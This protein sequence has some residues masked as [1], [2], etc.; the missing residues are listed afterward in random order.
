MVDMKLLTDIELAQLTAKTLGKPIIYI[1]GFG[2]ENVA[3]DVKAA[4]YLANWQNDNENMA[5]LLCDGSG[6]ILCDNEE[7]MW[8]YYKLTVGDDGPTKLNPYIGPA[9]VYALTIH[10]NGEMGTENT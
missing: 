10:A 1:S 9:R 3:E 7:E 6:F 8:H 2:G 4:P 5:Q